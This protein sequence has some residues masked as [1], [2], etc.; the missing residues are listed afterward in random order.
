MTRHN[1]GF[2]MVDTFFADWK[3]EK[4]FKSLV[5]TDFQEKI[6]S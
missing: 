5:S 6:L 3:E 2:M 4:K 1:I